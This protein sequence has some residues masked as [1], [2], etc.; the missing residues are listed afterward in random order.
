MLHRS[1]GAIGVGQSLHI[2]V[3]AS[4]PE[5]VP[6]TKLLGEEE[7]ANKNTTPHVR[8]AIE[9]KTRMKQYSNW[10]DASL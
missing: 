4:S 1:D 7:S 5:V 9:D 6:T 8:S 10:L 3:C 2:A